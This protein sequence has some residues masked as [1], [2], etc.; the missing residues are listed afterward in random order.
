MNSD[1]RNKMKAIVA[2]KYGPPEVLKLREVE[3]PTIRTD[4]LLIRIHATTVSAGDCELR[5]FEMPFLFWLP[6][7]IFMGIRR[8][9]HILGTEVAGVVEAVGDEGSR[10]KAWIPE[11]YNDEI[12]IER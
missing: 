7:R 8:P 1:W 9:K 6:L 10:F 2:S 5:R 3:K 12:R 11:M 4:E